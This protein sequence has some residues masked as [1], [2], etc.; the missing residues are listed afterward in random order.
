MATSI[1]P[2]YPTYPQ[3]RFVVTL[4]EVRLRLTLTWRA[5]TVSWYADVHTAAGA[6]LVLGRRLAAGWTPLGAVNL[7]DDHPDGVLLCRGVEDY[8]QADL[9]TRLQLVFV[10]QADVD[11]VTAASAAASPTRLKFTV[12]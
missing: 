4:G 1:L 7:G 5:R 3:H 2:G 8:E 10:P 11:V 6:E 12:S 9:G